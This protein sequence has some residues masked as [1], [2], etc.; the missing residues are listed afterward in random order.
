MPIILRRQDASRFEMHTT[1]LALSFLCCV[2][3]CYGNEFS[4]SK[5]QIEQFSSLVSNILRGIDESVGCIKRIAVLVLYINWQLCGSEKIANLVDDLGT[6][7]CH[8]RASSRTAIACGALLAYS[9]S[10]PRA[11]GEFLTESALHYECKPETLKHLVTAYMTPKSLLLHG[12]S[13]S[14]LVVD[15]KL[16]FHRSTPYYILLHILNSLESLPNSA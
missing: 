8:I 5:Q 2:A 4:I 7:E 16:F 11:A 14:G 1:I 3:V 10:I 12:D 13:E 15:Y 6:L 9:T